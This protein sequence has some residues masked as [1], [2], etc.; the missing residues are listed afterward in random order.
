MEGALSSEKGLKLQ[1]QGQAKMIELFMR[2]CRPVT[3]VS[4]G[5]E[6]LTLA[7]GGASVESPWVIRGS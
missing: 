6:V 5:E 3:S 1:G 4:Q 7:I 2:Y